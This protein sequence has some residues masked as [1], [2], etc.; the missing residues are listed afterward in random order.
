MKKSS[1]TFNFNP[2]KGVIK[3][4]TR[5][6][7]MAS[8]WA[9]LS[10]LIACS[11]QPHQHFAVGGAGEAYPELKTNAAALEAWKDM[12]FGMFVHWGPVSLAGTEIGWSRGREI[13][14]STY[15]SLYLR[16]NPVNFDANE[17]ISI[18]KEAGMKYFVIILNE[19]RF[20]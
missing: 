8:L 20:A 13:P 7:T 10:I 17:W 15:D 4:V 19:P 9:S 18:A 14:F 2:T 6:V 12:R 3:G 1:F 11:N 16:F 5:G